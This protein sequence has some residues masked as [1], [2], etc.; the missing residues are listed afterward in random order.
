M[1][2]KTS[3]RINQWI[4]YLIFGLG[5]TMTIVVAVQVFFRYVLNHSLFWSEELAR[6]LLVWLTFLGASS[7]YYRKVNPGVD[8]LYAKLTPL[9]KK[10]SSISTHLASMSLFIVMIIYGYQFAWFVRLQISP[11]LQIPKW[12][13]L[14][15]I[16]ISGVILMI[17]AVSFLFAELKEDSHDH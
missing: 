6:F 8:F 12:I 2:E 4:E 9:L 1:I 10:I 17:H 7:A 5:F 14:S 16:P 11:A 13:I 3:S 15:I